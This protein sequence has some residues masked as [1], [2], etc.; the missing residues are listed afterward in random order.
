MPDFSHRATVQ[1]LMDDLT[2]GGNDLHQAL[3]ELDTI[4]ALLGGNRVTLDGIAALLRETPESVHLRIADVGCG[5]GDLLRLTRNLLEKQSRA[6]SLTGIDANPNVV[7]YAVAHTPARYK[8]DYQVMNIF[9]EAFDNTQFDIVMGTLFFHHLNDAQL[10]TFL[11]K[12]KAQVSIGMVI[13]DIHRNWFAY[14]AIMWL[15]RFFSRSPMV[16]HDATRS[17]LRAFR[18]HELE[19]ILKV[20]GIARYTLRWRWAFRWQLI[21]RF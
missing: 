2:S 13:N 8:I 21:I 11:R 1:E 9:S 18:K 17:V 4:N 6:A 15:T 12:M 16:R 7:A 14:Y 19:S 20:A 10:T 3:R 5:S